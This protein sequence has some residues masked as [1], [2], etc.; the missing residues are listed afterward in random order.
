MMEF[1]ERIKQVIATCAGGNQ[2]AFV[3]KIGES[4][5]TF[6]GYL[7]PAGQDRIKAKTIRQILVTFDVDANWLLLGAGPMFREVGTKT[8]PGADPIAQRVDQV[9]RTMREAGVDE[10]KI[11]AAARDVLEG[12][13]AKLAKARGGYSVCEPAP[14]E[15]AKAA[16]DP[17][18]YSG[19]QAAAGDDT[20]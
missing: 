10:M 8:L 20:V 5:S 18:E 6:N 7:S 19:R 1:Y 9:A 13:M 17:A 14:D 3:K 4:I 2:S 11:L 12:E 15:Q 16:E